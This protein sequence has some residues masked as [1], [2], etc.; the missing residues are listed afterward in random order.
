MTA[1]D[2]LETCTRLGIILTVDAGRL[3]YRAPK[4]VMTPQIATQITE[5][6]ADI[7]GLL[8]QPGRA[9]NRDLSSVIDGKTVREIILRGGQMIW[10]QDTCGQH[11]RYFPALNRSFVIDVITP[12]QNK[13]KSKPRQTRKTKGIKQLAFFLDKA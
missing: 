7:I 10:F 5:N 9:S 8:V 1:T 12:T 13:S 11:W 2:L 4:G 6:R 3:R